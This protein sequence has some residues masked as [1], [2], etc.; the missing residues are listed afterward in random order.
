MN[1][2]GIIGLGQIGGG[3]AATLAKAGWK[4]FGY[5]ISPAAQNRARAAGVTLAPDARAVFETSDLTLISLPSLDAIRDIYAVLRSSGRRPGAMIAEC[6]TV[7][8]DMAK[9]LAAISIATGRD[10][11]E[12]AVIGTGREAADGTLYFLVA[13]SRTLVQGLDPILSIAGRGYVHLGPIGAASL[14]KVLNNAIGLAT[15]LA[16]AEAI[17][18]AE[19]AGVDP[20]AF[21][22]AVIDGNGA[23]ASV[24]FT[25]HAA[26]AAAKEPQ[27]PT[28]LNLK[29]SLALDALIAPVRDAYPMLSLTV[30][31]V[32]ALIGSGETGLAWTAA[33]TARQTAGLRDRHR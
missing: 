14:A 32:S 5:D 15:I 23:G 12:M 22:R 20:D 2:V 26:R 13:G 7:A 6:S 18:E 10:H 11:V 28:P 31:R 30:D 8:V 19:R 4:A 33:E 29:D 9:E 25:R 16:L 24:V 3:I 1:S 17:A 21:I 27:P